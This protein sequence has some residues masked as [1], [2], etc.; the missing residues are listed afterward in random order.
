M[1]QML[2]CYADAY[3]NL[4][5]NKV[6]NSALEYGLEM[7]KITEDDWD[8]D[9]IKRYYHRYRVRNGKDLLYNKEKPL[10]KL[11]DLQ[12]NQLPLDL[13]MRKNLEGTLFAQMK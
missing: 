10:V 9:S 4:H 2:V 1:K 5:A 6:L 11:S 12:N 7:M 13:A 3:L 8:V